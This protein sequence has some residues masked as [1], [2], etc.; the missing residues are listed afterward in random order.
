MVI[1]LKDVEHLAGLARIEVSDTEKE[2]LRHD[3]EGIL[4]YVSQIK[5]VEGEQEEQVEQVELRNVMRE[6]SEPHKAGI[7]TEDILKQAPR[8]DGNRISV[9]KIM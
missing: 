8:R 2:L 4:E 5:K 7:F 3:L 1:E 6:D 9:K